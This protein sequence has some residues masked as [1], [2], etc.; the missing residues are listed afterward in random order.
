MAKSAGISLEEIT[1]AIQLLSNA[2]VQGEMV[3]TTLRGIL[4]SQT[5]PTA[6][7]VK[8]MAT[9][10]GANADE[11]TALAGRVPEDLPAIIQKQPTAMPELLREASG[12]TADQLRFLCEQARKLN[13]RGTPGGGGWVKGSV[14]FV[15]NNSKLT[16][17]E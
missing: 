13:E 7:R 2:G 5:S 3:G 17:A 15:F 6:E 10:L 11:W 16:V 14:P 4:L 1:A 8:T 9:L 12:L